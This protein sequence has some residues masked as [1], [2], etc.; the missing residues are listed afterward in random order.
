VELAS[1]KLRAHAAQ[2]G[3]PAEVLDQIA[4]LYDDD[5]DWSAERR[6]TGVLT[7]EA[8]KKFVFQLPQPR[9]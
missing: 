6:G 9:I 2:C 5:D 4:D 7:A 1:V 8:R 3:E